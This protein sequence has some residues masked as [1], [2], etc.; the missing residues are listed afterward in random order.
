MYFITCLKI[1]LILVPTTKQKKKYQ[2]YVFLEP[3]KITFDV[4]IKYN[5]YLNFILVH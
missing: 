3:Y 4:N 5:V 2:V 1:L